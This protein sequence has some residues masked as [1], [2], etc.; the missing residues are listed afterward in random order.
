MKK[1]IIL[2][3]FL[4]LLSLQL[5]ALNTTTLQ[6]SSLTLNSLINSINATGDFTSYPLPN[7]SIQIPPEGLVNERVLIFIEKLY[8][9]APE[10]TQNLTNNILMM[11]KQDLLDTLSNLNNQF[12]DVSAQCGVGE[13]PFN[14]T[15]EEVSNLTIP[16]QNFSQT[17]QTLIQFN[18]EFSNLQNQLQQETSNYLN[19]LLNGIE[20]NPLCIPNLSQL[21]QSTQNAETSL[22]QAIA[23]EKNNTWIK[24]SQ[25]MTTTIEKEWSA[26][27]NPFLNS[28]KT[29]IE[30]QLQLS[31]SNQ[32]PLKALDFLI[33]LEDMIL[34]LRNEKGV[35]L[36]VNETSTFYQN[37][38]ETFNYSY[39]EK[40]LKIRGFVERMSN[41]TKTAY[42]DLDVNFIQAPSNF[43]LNL[44]RGNQND[45]E[46]SFGKR[47]GTL[48][49]MISINKNFD[50]SNIRNATFSFN[51]SKESLDGSVENYSNIILLTNHKGEV[52]RLNFTSEDMG[53]YYEITFTTPKLSD[54][55]AYMIQTINPVTSS[56]ATPASAGPTTTSTANPSSASQ[57][58]LASAF[59]TSF[60]AVTTFIA[61]A[62]IGAAYFL[63]SKKQRK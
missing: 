33:K 61:V 57:P 43:T 18:Q 30:Q 55:A 3:L 23:S 11:G 42:V 4:A 16:K 60:W 25:I 27:Q 36:Q 22:E 20:N 40:K 21:N 10:Q 15:I 14:K 12:Y 63:T 47:N 46:K 49:L 13:H 19:F 35:V 56:Q 5:K 53:D 45:F 50:D 38:N 29:E 39:D 34:A 59:T 1:L 8:E 2:L 31:L 51:F 52:S 32:D 28:K 54:F 24:I 62:V 9:I 58:T 17:I 7:V 48:L 26:V 6:D 44:T 37:G 41:S